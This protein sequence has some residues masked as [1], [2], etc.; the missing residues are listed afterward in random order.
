MEHTYNPLP[1]KGKEILDMP[2][3]IETYS[4]KPSYGVFDLLSIGSTICIKTPIIQLID[5]NK[6]NT[7]V[8]EELNRATFNSTIL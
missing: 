7:V 2:S 3:L 8:L 4:P 5:I 1:I 6:S